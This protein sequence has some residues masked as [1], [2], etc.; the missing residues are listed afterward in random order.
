[1]KQYEN[2]FRHNWRVLQ[3]MVNYIILIVM[4]ISDHSENPNPK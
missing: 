1:M 3:N 2:P 4:A